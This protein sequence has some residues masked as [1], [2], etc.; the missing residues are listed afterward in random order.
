MPPRP[1]IVLG[2]WISSGP[3]AHGPGAKI[4]CVGLEVFVAKISPA[5][6]TTPSHSSRTQPGFYGTPQ[7]LPPNFRGGGGT[8]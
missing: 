4:A 6:T 5:A 7:E 3:A 1:K 2:S 8:Q